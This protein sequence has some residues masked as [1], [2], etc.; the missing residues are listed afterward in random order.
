MVG[1]EFYYVFSFLG[2]FEFEQYLLCDVELGFD[3]LLKD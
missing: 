1:I 3:G 2:V